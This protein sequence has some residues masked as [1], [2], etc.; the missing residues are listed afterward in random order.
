MKPKYPMLKRRL[1]VFAAYGLLAVGLVAVNVLAGFIPVRIDMTEEGLYTLSEGTQN[2]LAGLEEPVT[3]KFFFN[4]SHPGLPA[5]IKLHARKV[6]ELL[7]EY[8]SRSGE[9]VTL[10]VLDPKP[11]SDEEEWATRYGLRGAQLPTGTRMFLGLVALSAN[12]EAVIPFFDTRRERFLEYDISET[13]SRVSRR[14]KEKVAVLAYLPITGQ[15][16]PRTGTRQGEWAV[17]REMRKLFDLETYFPVE[18]VEIPES[19]DLLL[20]VHPRKVSDTVAYALDQFLMRGGRMIVFTDP[21]SRYDVSNTQGMNSQFSSN[22]AQLYKAWNIKFNHEEVVA[23]LALATRV[24]TQQDG[25]VEYPVW[26]TVRGD[27]LNRDSVITSQLEQ[28]TI[29]DAGAF[30]TEEG[31]KYSFTPLLT[32]STTSGVVDRITVRMSQPLALAKTVQPDGKARVLAA[33]L[34]GTFDSAFPQGAPPP[35]MEKDDKGK[36]VAKKIERKLPHLAK[37]RAESSV[38]L[39][40]DAD[41]MQ[42]RFTVRAINFFGQQVYQPINDNMSF[43][44]NSVEALIGSQELIHIRSRGRLGRPFTKIFELQ[45]NAQRRYKKREQKL[46]D[47][48]EEVRKR[49]EGLEEQKKGAKQV[50]LNPA[51]LAEIK[52]FR[53]EE[54]DTKRALREVRKVL[55]QDIEFLGN[56]LLLIN[57]LAVPLLVGVAGFVTIIR[58]SR[59]SGG[60]A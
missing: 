43:V 38:L 32:S 35:P 1:T 37:A 15:I 52:Q 19:I 36:E 40:G 23:D 58:R 56:M 45:V 53:T 33:L 5:S 47:E 60:G 54:A 10:E 30:S 59:R 51:Q 49:L 11:D 22:L 16:N 27:H 39:V 3:L 20:V 42:D 7:E 44:L 31:F 24:N 2:I 25:T 6:R 34:T 18:L 28:L 48:L 17:I 21:F 26:L 29:P 41:F 57:M 55:R 50:L 46:S 4:E 9:N 14:S 12:Q 8:A 13:I